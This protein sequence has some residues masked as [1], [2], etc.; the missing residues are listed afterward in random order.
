LRIVNCS[1]ATDYLQDLWKKKKIN[2][3]ILSTECRKPRVSISHRF[4]YDWF[5]NGGAFMW[6]LCIIYANETAP[7]KYRRRTAFISN[8]H[9]SSL[10]S[11]KPIEP[12][13]SSPANLSALH[14]STI[15]TFVLSIPQRL[16]HPQI[17]ITQQVIINILRDLKQNPACRDINHGLQ[18]YFSNI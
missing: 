1:A 11:Y 16:L 17:P 6:T 18:D 8:T 9:K 15:P 14:V 3:L 12:S 7:L 5:V 2:F 13:V 10:Q 4:H